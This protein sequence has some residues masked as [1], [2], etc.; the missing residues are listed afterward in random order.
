[1]LYH[2]QTA[3]TKQAFRI[4]EAVAAYGVGRTTLYRL[5]G[6]GRIRVSKV[7]KR[8]LIAKSE[9]DA[10]IALPEGEAA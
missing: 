4:K 3:P 8:T 6:E 10:L 2:T 5:I 9:L 1:M 7:G